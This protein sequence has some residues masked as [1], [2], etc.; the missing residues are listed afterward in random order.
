M[1]SALDTGVVDAPGG[2]ALGW[3]RFPAPVPGVGLSVG[4]RARLLPR[5]SGILEPVMLSPLLGRK[6]SPVV[7]LLSVSLAASRGLSI[8]TVSRMEGGGEDKGLS[9]RGKIRKGNS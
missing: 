3:Q 2:L 5:S 6:E 9:E 7:P 4:T 8:C 1:P